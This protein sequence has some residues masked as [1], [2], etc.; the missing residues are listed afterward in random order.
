MPS[1]P[2]S[3]ASGGGRVRNGEGATSQAPPPPPETARHDAQLILGQLH[4]VLHTAVEHAS[5]WSPE[6][7]IEL[8]R[9]AY[10]DLGRSLGIAQASLNSGDYDEKLAPS[11][12]AGP[13]AG[14]KKHAVFASVDGFYRAVKA[15]AR[16][17][18]G[19]LKSVLRWGRTYV[20]SLSFVPGVEAVGEFIEVIQN[21]IED[22]DGSEA[23]EPKD[24]QRG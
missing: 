8:V 16:D 17:L 2:E 5:R 18:V 21:S 14:P 12:L 10:L 4:G 6:E 3:R 13:Q 19:P 7:R 20:G 23:P 22:A 11:G 9:A 1:Q 15:K 24:P